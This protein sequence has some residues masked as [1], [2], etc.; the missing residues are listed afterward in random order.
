MFEI[1]ENRN[2]K[3]SSSSVNSNEN[4]GC[5]IKIAPKK[6]NLTYWRIWLWLFMIEN[7]F[8]TIIRFIL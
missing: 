8:I 1:L 5:K 3:E 2:K 6:S 7:A 4:W